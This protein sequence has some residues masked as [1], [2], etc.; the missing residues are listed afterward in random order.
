MPELRC[1]GQD[2]R[3][4]KPEDIFISP[5][6]ECGCEIEFWKDEPFLNCRECGADVR[7]PRVDLGCAAWCPAAAECLGRLA[8]DSDMVVPIRDRLMKALGEVFGDDRRRIDHA[9]K[10]CEYADAICEEEG[11]SPV[12][13]KAAALLH[14]VGIPEAERRHGSAAGQFQERLGPP[15]AKRILEQIPLAPELIAHVCRII[16]SHHSGRD[17]DTTEFRVI[18]DSDWLVNLPA[19]FPDDTPEQRADR[20]RKLLRTETGKRIGLAEL[21]AAASASSTT[22]AGS[23]M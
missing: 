23:G 12:V 1:P 2:R 15:I 14:D 20:I 6:P 4:W 18:W 10:V 8:T 7:N 16:G 11:G 17:I 13:V 22:L 3:F 5:C 19:E 21:S 9:L